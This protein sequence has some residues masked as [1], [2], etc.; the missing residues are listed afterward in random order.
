MDWVLIFYIFVFLFG[1]YILLT[2]KLYKIDKSNRKDKNYILS[3]AKEGDLILFAGKTMSEKGVMRWTNTNSSH[4]CLVLKD[5]K[6]FE[7]DVKSGEYRGGARIIP[8]KDRLDLWRGEDTF[9]LVEQSKKIDYDLIE[10]LIGKEIE[11]NYFGWFMGKK[12][13]VN[14]LLCSEAVARVLRIDNPELSFPGMWERS[15]K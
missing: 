3:N 10:E 2:V 14:K 12:W 7:A 8:L 15:F 1:I 5:G 9:L 4:V 6:V 11:L 13:D